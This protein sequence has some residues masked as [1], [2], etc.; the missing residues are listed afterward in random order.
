[1]S[2]R[3]KS[4]KTKTMVHR[5]LHRQIDRATP[6]N[7]GEISRS[8]MTT[9]DNI[10]CFYSNGLAY[11]GQPRFAFAKSLKI[12]KTY[13]NRYLNM[14][15]NTELPRRRRLG[16]YGILYICQPPGCISRVT[17]SYGLNSLFC[18][19]IKSPVCRNYHDKI[20]NL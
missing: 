10:S 5:T 18:L 9:L 16:G 12:P 8:G 11:F 7:T 20:Y 14:I 2:K 17:L 1:M 6:Q 15:Y 4:G 13:N 19:L 3:K